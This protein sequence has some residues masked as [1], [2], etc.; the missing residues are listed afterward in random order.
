LENYTEAQEAKIAKEKV[1][2]SIDGR[3]YKVPKGLSVLE[4]ARMVHI[5]IPNLCYLKD[6]NEVG[7]C[8]VCVVE[9][10]GTRNLQASCVYPVRDGLKIR[11][12]T[13]RV[14]RARKTAVALILSNHN[15]E[16]LTC[17]RNLNCELQNVADN[18]GVRNIPFTGT[19]AENYGFHDANPAIQRDYNK[20]IKCRR[21]LAICNQIQEC[22]V[23][24]ALNRGMDTI[25]APA[26]QKDLNEVTCI[27]CGQCVIACPTASLSEK[28]SIPEVWQAIAD[29][30]KYVIAQ[31]APSIQVTIG[32]VFGMPLG[33]FVAGKLVAVLRRI[34]FDKVFATDVTADLTIME[35]G[36]ELVHRITKTPENLPLLSS[37]CPGWVKFAEHFYPEFL[38]HVSSTKSPHEMCGALAKTWYAKKYGI[39]PS[40]I[41]NVAI[42]P[43]TAKKYE[44]ARPEMESDGFRNVDYVLT[45]RELARMIRQVGINFAELDDE[46]YD[47]PFDQYSGAGM[48]FGATGG[49]LEAAIRTAYKL[50]NNE[51]ML[52][53][54]FEDARGQKGLKYTKFT[55][56]GKTITAAVAH[57]TGNAKKALDAF[58]SGEKKFDYL[59]VMACPGGCVGGGGQPILGSRDHNKISLDYRHNRAD[60]LYNAERGKPIRRSHDNPR[61]QQIY[62]E[63][64]GHPL[65]DLSKKYLHTAYVDR[66]KHPY[67]KE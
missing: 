6:I 16:C 1:I 3:N 34:G 58:I 49:V 37:C 64:L 46:A 56:G 50:V 32:E 8:R 60:S 10:E 54:D 17:V 38:P 30:S 39:D 35:E 66:G 27:M 51:E 55:L 13:E 4:A 44:A 59:E 31:T 22:H 63:F 62:E 5:D 29:P 47:E 52:V 45:T 12:N 53:P 20:C 23:Y 28:E 36:S 19:E 65:S 48:I 61:V 40:T 11:T 33:S 41:V 7:I 9:V 42:M 25:I 24:S 2:I 18:L 14:R 57:G 15:R 26:F 67:L 43:C 21:C